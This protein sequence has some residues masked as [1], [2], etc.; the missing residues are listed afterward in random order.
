M[1]KI[2]VLLASLLLAFDAHASQINS[3]SYKQI[4]II[5]TGGD[6]VTSSTYKTYTA[7]GIINRIINSTS[8]LNKL[9]FFYTWLLAD[10][11]PCSLD[12][13]C[14]GGYCCS[15]LC[16]NS[17]CP[18][19]GG[20]SSGVSGGGGAGGG[21]YTYVCNQDWQCGE[22]SDCINGLQTRQCNLA[23]VA[24]HAQTEPC[25]SADNPPKTSKDCKA[26]FSVSPNIIKEHLKIGASKIQKIKIKNSQDSPISFD[27]NVGTISDFVFLSDSS[28]T[29]EPGQEKE[30]EVN[31]VG[32]KLGSYFGEL[33]VNGNGARKAVTIVV[34][35]ESGQVLFDAKIDIP[36]NYKQVAPGKDLRAQITLLNVGPPRKVDV[37]ATFIIK[38]KRGNVVSE[39]SETFA[40]EKQVSFVKVFS[41]P[42]SLAPDDYLAVIEV[43][44]ENSFA[45][46]SELFKV[47][48]EKPILTRAITSNNILLAGLFIF[49]ITLI[50][51]S[52]RVISK[53]SYRK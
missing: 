21:G 44:Y 8:Y 7:F 23:K 40:V 45:V 38:D 36:S 34:E 13:Q 22:W 41:I 20:G 18:S 46:S 29:L 28:F 50:L 37:T 14:E 9:G 52:Y 42:S 6:N 1:K 47:V 15:N 27:L 17:A 49:V 11:Q 10:N 30:I 35:V 48:K 2:I 51:I 24:Q 4:V 32:R 5:S 16:S 26:E 3:S 12:S 39:S 19:G 25:P 43:R 31:I 33:E 53:K